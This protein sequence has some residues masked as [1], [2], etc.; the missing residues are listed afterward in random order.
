MM[1]YLYKGLGVGRAA[2][3]RATQYAYVIDEGA[4]LIT[5]RGFLTL[6]D[7]EPAE[8]LVV[9]VSEEPVAD[10]GGDRWPWL[11]QQLARA[12]PLQGGVVAD[13]GAGA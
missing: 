4:T 2:Y 13:E 5:A 12:G 1:T 8:E 11:Y 10:E 9:T 6:E 3:W 7:E